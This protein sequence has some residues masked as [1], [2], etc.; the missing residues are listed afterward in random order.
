TANV[1][2]M[3]QMFSDCQSLAS[4]DLSG[5]N[6]EKVKYMSSMF[7]D[8]YSLKMLDLSNFKGAPTGVEYMFANC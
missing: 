8:C 1:T 5:F 3:S 4:L 7:Y 2:D 6:T